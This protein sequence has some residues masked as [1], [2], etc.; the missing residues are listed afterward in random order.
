MEEGY[1]E[2]GKVLFNS[3]KDADEHFGPE[4]ELEVTWE[5]LSA[6]SYRHGRAVRDSIKM[7]NAIQVTVENKEDN[8]L[9][10]HEITIWTGTRQ[11]F[12]SKRLYTIKYLHGLFFCD[13]TNRF[14]NIQA[15]I[16]GPVFDSYRPFLKDAITSIVCHQ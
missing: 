3:Q 15:R 8:W 10:S 2:Q 9:N 11:K 1:Y 6:M 13:A 7:H 16:Y 4:A 5:S 12:I 14:F